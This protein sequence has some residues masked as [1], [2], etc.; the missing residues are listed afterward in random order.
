M[1]DIIDSPCRLLSSHQHLSL[2]VAVP[3]L[4]SQEELDVDEEEDF[5]EEDDFTS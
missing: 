3:A 2:F 5:S 1:L 4:N